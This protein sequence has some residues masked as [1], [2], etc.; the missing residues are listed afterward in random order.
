MEQADK[1]NKKIVL[2]TM[3]ETTV[4]FSIVQEMGSGKKLPV[5]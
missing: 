5:M 2:M 4:S 3:M 1:G